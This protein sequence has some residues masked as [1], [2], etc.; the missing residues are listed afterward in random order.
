MQHCGFQLV[1]CLLCRHDS[2]HW[3]FLDS[4]RSQFGPWNEYFRKSDG[5]WLLGT[6]IYCQRYRSSLRA[7]PYS[8]NHDDKS[9]DHHVSSLDGYAD[10]YADT[11]SDDKHD[12]SRDSDDDANRQLQQ[13]LRLWWLF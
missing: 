1:V 2:R 11:K 6:W 13:N 7:Q 4:D 5:V 10:T 3:S 9:N 12:T 8:N